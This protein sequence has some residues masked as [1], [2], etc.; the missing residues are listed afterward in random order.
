MKYFNLYYVVAFL[1]GIGIFLFNH[2]MSSE[3]VFFYGFAENKE[4]EINFN[5][6]VVVDEILVIPGQEV[7]IGTP[8]LKLKRVKP[9]ERMEDHDFQIEE[10]SA[11]AQQWK[12][13]KKGDLA[14]LRS[15]RELKVLE[16]D[17]ELNKLEE[18][19]RFKEGLYKDLKSID[20]SS[21]TYTPITDKIQSLEKQKELAL[22]NIDLEIKNIQEEIRL[23]MNPFQ[24]EIRRLKA[25]HIFEQN[26]KVVEVELKA[27][28]KGVIGNIYCKRA[29]HIPSFKTLM[30]FY[31]PN[32]TQ[33]KGF[34]H[35][36]QILEVGLADSLVI[37]S[38]KDENIFC[39]GRV[40]GLGSRIVEI[41][42]RLRK[43]PDLK[44]YGGEILVSIPSEN[45]FLQKEKVGLEI[46][47]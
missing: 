27:P 22:G 20:S 23:G 28:A 29:E 35:E 18:E 26:N 36:D 42:E 30:I 7:E 44:T 9:K 10:L 11:K 43:I 41:P 17:T 47:E 3:T 14:L 46:I 1:M 4:T 45:N 34:I 31:E 15:E 19:R 24:V 13:E 6:P 38:T 2:F 39:K 40:N 21:L 37:R 8:L 12:T 5:Y 16:F 32:P 25:E 33:V